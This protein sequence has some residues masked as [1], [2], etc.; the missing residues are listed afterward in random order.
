MICLELHMYTLVMS[1][2]S[3]S[4]FQKAESVVRQLAELFLSSDYDLVKLS[5]MSRLW[6]MLLQC[7]KVS[8]EKTVKAV[9][10][11]YT[12]YEKA[13]NLR[14]NKAEF[15]F[16]KPFFKEVL[17]F[18]MCLSSRCK[19]RTFLYNY[20]VTGDYYGDKL[21]D[22]SGAFYTQFFH[23]VCF[24]FYRVKAEVW[25]AL[26]H[27]TTQTIAKFKSPSERF[28]FSVIVL[29]NFLN[30]YPRSDNLMEVNAESIRSYLSY[31]GQLITNHVVQN[32]ST[33]KS[34]LSL[35]TLQL[36]K[37]KPI[38]S[39]HFFEEQFAGRN[40][41]GRSHH[42]GCA[43]LAEVLEKHTSSD[44]LKASPDFLEL[45]Q[46]SFSDDSSEKQSLLSDRIR[47]CFVGECI[48]F[49]MSVHNL[50][51]VTSSDNH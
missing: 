44:S 50:F 39:V 27:F 4:I 32:K 13:I 28:E 25:P 14:D 1:G 45:L 24:A 42:A 17:T 26:T 3:F 2:S 43:E 8:N 46:L 9:E 51:K 7:A 29:I 31:L 12:D 41:L 36:F 19:L 30:C 34:T 10:N 47:D 37:A 5:R 38:F 23:L 22:I 40:V 49:G 16:L 33:S 48:Q 11:R 20:A 15:A 35:E 6:L 21:A 18:S